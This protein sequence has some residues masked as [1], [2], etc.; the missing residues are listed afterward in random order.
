MRR[1]IV[2]YNAYKLRLDKIF[3]L[4]YSTF[5][6]FKTRQQ[7]SYSILRIFFASYYTYMISD[8]FVKIRSKRLNNYMVLS[9]HAA[10]QKTREEI[11]QY[12]KLRLYKY[13]HR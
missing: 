11:S 13:I 10:R 9:P 4:G 5:L 12:Y 7:I 2:L 3:R 8:V 6:F 1:V